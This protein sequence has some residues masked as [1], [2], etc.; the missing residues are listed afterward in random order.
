MP[1]VT[2]IYWRDI[3]AQVT[4]GSGRGATRAVLSQRFQEAID[5]AAMAAGL[6]GADGYLTEWRRETR[7]VAAGDAEGA[8]AAVRDELETTYTDPVLADLARAG[9]LKGDA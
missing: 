7:A 3:P 9:G 1:D 4:V 6:F 8:V 5:A 2:V